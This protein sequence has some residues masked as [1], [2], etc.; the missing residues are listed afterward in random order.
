LPLLEKISQEVSNMPDELGPVMEQI[1][2]CHRQIAAGANGA[3]TTQPAVTP[4]IA[5]RKPHA[6]PVAGQVVE[7]EIKQLGNFAYDASVGG[8]IPEDVKRLDGCQFRTRGF[9]ISLDETD[10]VSQFALVPTLGICCS[11]SPPQIQHTIVV[12]IPN[13]KTV[14]FDPDEMIVEGI[15]HVHEE[16]DGGFIVSIFQLDATSVRPAQ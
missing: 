13:G 7:M 14:A 4:A 6:A 10:N 5:A 1:R 9:M 16:K 2:I 15:L 8:N 12:H 3:A 11:G